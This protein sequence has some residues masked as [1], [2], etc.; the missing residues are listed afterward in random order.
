MYRKVMRFVHLTMYGKNVSDVQVGWGAT[1]TVAGLAAGTYNVSPE[2][3]PDTAGN[4]YQG[5][6]SPNSITWRQIKRLLLQLHMPWCNR[7]GK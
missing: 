7:S 5:T 4:S 2:S 3:V 6:A 1:K